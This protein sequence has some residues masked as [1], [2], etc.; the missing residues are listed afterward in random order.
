MAKGGKEA[1]RPA[2]EKGPRRPPG[3]ERLGAQARKIMGKHYAS[4]YRTR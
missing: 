2:K 1:P 4:K 3:N